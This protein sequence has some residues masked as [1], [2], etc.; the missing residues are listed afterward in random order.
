MNP[1]IERLRRINAGSS[2]T[3]LSSHEASTVAAE[4][5]GIPEDYLC[6]LR[7]VGWGSF[8][9][10]AFAL[11]SGPATWQ[12]IFSEAHPGGL[13]IIL[14]G[15]DF[16]G[17]HVGYLRTVDRYMLVELDHVDVSLP[18]PSPQETLSRFL[19]DWLQDSYPG[20]GSCSP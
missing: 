11:Y 15:D 9:D 13:D 20:D 19:L 10:Q 2:L 12:S 4:Y 1:D 14:L 18:E 6:L 5:P 17:Y 8:G 7:E 16:A 3:R